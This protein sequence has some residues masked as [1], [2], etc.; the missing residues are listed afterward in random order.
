MCMQVKHNAFLNFVFLENNFQKK[1]F[2]KTN[3]QAI[4]IY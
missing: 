1:M 2:E 4:F 3:F